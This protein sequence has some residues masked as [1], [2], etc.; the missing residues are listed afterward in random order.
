MNCSSS[1]EE[2]MGQLNRRRLLEADDRGALR[3]ERGEHVVHGAVLATGVHRLQH[4]QHRV[5]PLCVQESLLVGE[6][7]AELFHLLSCRFR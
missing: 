4:N 5:L 7:L 3:I 6:F 2:I 1:P